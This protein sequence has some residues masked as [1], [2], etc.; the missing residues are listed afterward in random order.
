MDC[1]T[2]AADSLVFRA[3]SAVK[4]GHSADAQELPPLDLV[5]AAIARA[6]RLAA[7]DDRARAPRL[8]LH[9]TQAAGLLNATSARSAAVFTDRA[10][11]EG[12]PIARAL[13]TRGVLWRFH[14]AP[15]DAGAP[16]A[17]EPLTSDA[18]A[19]STGAR[20]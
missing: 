12:R 20:A 18:S 15:A 14:A 2:H 19:R 3:I 5:G 13:V 16:L 17:Y 8:A 11:D 4:C 10:A 9:S 7:N 1:D 6:A